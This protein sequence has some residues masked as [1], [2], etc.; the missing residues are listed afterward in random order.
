MTWAQLN[1][2]QKPCV[3]INT[4]GYYDFLLQFLDQAVTEGFVRPANLNLVKV[5]DN[6]AEALAWIEQHRS[7][8]LLKQK[9]VLQNRGGLK[10]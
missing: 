4:N 6:S 3:L 1:I 10:P 7:K 2:H 9:D 8:A 5:A